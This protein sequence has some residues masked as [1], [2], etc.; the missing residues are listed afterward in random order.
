MDK[1]YVSAQ[2]AIWND[3]ALINE[4]LNMQKNLDREILEKKEHADRFDL[5]NLDLA[6]IDEVGEL[7]HEL[8]SEWCWWKDTQKRVESDKVLGELVDIWHFVLMKHYKTEK[9]DYS[10]KDY[11]NF[12]VWNFKSGGQYLGMN[13]IR[14]FLSTNYEMDDVLALTFALDFTLIDVY[15]AYCEKNKVNHERVENGY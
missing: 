1:Y 12:L 11:L 3:V 9:G 8:K 7:T 13:Y 4:M 15:E 2:N 14:H 6:I 10:I 5:D